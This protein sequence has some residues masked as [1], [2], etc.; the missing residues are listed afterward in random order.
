MPPMQPPEKQGA[1]RLGALLAAL[2]AIGLVGAFLVPHLLDARR[3][4]SEAAAV[5]A[6]GEILKA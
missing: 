6:L 3:T 2:T 4:G 5:Q 1:S